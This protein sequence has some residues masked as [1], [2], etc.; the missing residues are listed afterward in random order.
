[1]NGMRRKRISDDRPSLFEAWTL[2]QAYGIL[3]FVLMVGCHW[4]L[5]YG[6]TSED[7]HPI[8]P[9]QQESRSSPALK[10][11]QQL[12]DQH[13]HSKAW[14]TIFAQ[15]TQYLSH[16]HAIGEAMEKGREEALKQRI[17]DNH[18]HHINPWGDMDQQIHY[19][20]SLGSLH[21]WTGKR[22]STPMPSG[23]EK[24]IPNRYRL[25][26]AMGIGTNRVHLS[27]SIEDGQLFSS[28]L[29]GFHI[30]ARDGTP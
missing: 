25:A 15:R 7:P 11:L 17:G 14:Q 22:V 27:I 24:A 5:V 16:L 20:P 4:V 12:G 18:V 19:I 9:T 8:H 1:M 23:V 28:T 26:E 10:S 6:G 29:Y 13:I 21:Y 3:A 30:A 2:P